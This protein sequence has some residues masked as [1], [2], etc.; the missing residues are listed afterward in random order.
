MM[1]TLNDFFFEQGY[2]V[3]MCSL[4]QRYMSFV[5]EENYSVNI[6]C[7]FDERNQTSTS[8]Q[9]QAFEE[10]HRG[11]LD[12]GRGKDIHFLRLVC[13]DA[14]GVGT[15][16]PG[17]DGHGLAEEAGNDD[18]S[19]IN[20]VWYLIDD[21]NTDPD[22]G[23]PLGVRLFIPPEAAE[24]FYGIRAGLEKHVAEYGAGIQLPE[25]ALEAARHTR[26]ELDRAP[27]EEGPDG[28]P[29]IKERYEREIRKPSEVCWV[30]MGLLLINVV[31]Y[32]LGSMDIFND[33]DFSLD[34]NTLI[35]PTQWYRLITHM[36]LHS[37]LSHLTG[38]ML[39]LYA[40][41]SMV[42]EKMNRA[43][44][45]FMYF[46]SGICGGILSVW[47]RMQTGEDFYSLGASGAIYGIMGA[48]I[49]WMLMNRQWRSIRFYNRILI[50]ILLLFY[51]SSVDGKIDYMSHLGG[52]IAGLLF[53]G[54]YV[55]LTW[56][57][58]NNTRKGK[59]T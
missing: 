53:T 56:N 32:I 36:F 54:V 34:L 8:L 17:V 42:E 45:M 47:S 35:N 59:E 39:M 38:N 49:A 48:L 14:T 55:M 41:G 23:K 7:F 57:K 20:R 29:R 4:D 18:K 58:K 5:Q 26:D 44:Y 12:Y 33:R 21:A 15:L 19:W 52:F 30:T 43:V 37:S 51:G 50:A 46:F 40:A 24:D 10:V 13:T 3:Y 2:R 25:E 27:A 16:V 9:M 6:V 28:M 31:M 22:T 11:R 1:K